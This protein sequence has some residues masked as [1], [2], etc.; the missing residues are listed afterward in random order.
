MSEYHKILNVYRRDE[1]THKI[2]LGAFTTDELAFTSACQWEA[3]EK[4]DGTNIRVIYPNEQGGITVRGKTDR[5]QLK[6][7]LIEAIHAAF[8]LD[9]LREKCA[10]ATVEEPIVFYGEG[11][12]AGIGAN[13]KQ[14]GEEKKFILFDIKV[15]H[16]W[17]RRGDVIGLAGAVG[18]PMVPVVTRGTL[19]ELID[20]IGRNPISEVAQWQ[21]GRGHVFTMEGIVAR[22]AGCELFTRKGERLIVKVKHCDF[23][24]QG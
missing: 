4:V 13:G 19:H 7:D 17:L 23:G 5:A 14:Y 6:Q 18:S 3:T 8:N 10:S 1:Q 2:N 9:V 20:Y 12:G 16:W 21:R 15:G 22:P 24:F 11:Y